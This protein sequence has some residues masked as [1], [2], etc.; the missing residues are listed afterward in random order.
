MLTKTEHMPCHT[1]VPINF[2]GLIS[3]KAYYLIIMHIK[4]K[5]KNSIRYPEIKPNI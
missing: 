2:K 3:Y 5:I 1:Q 4:L